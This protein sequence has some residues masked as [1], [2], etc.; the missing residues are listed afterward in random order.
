MKAQLTLPEIEAQIKGLQRLARA[1]RAKE[2][3]AKLERDNAQLRLA[4]ETLQRQPPYDALVVHAALNLSCLPLSRAV[5][6]VAFARTLTG[7][8]SPPLRALG[9]FLLIPDPESQHAVWSL[10]CALHERQSPTVSLY[11]GGHPPAY[12]RLA[13]LLALE[14]FSVEIVRAALTLGA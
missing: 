13:D 5:V 11:F 6:R 2:K 3:L 8:T 1:E 9:E 10:L 14:G 7:P 4:V 12:Q